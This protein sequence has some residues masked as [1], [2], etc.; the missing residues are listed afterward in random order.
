MM[1]S[2]KQFY[3]AKVSATDGEI[4]AVKDFYFDGQNWT[5]RYLLVDTG[6]WLAARKVILSPHSLAGRPVCGKP[7]R[8]NLTRKKIEKSPS[9]DSHEPVLRQ[10][11]EQY[12]K[13]YGWPLYRSASATEMVGPQPE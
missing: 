13:Y 10:H 8:V 9:I 12:H 2:L 4:G 6:D 1:R 7:I 3:G 5:I 11:E